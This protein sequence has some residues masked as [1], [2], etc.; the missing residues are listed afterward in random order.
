MNSD[1]TDSLDKKQKFAYQQ[2]GFIK[3][4]VYLHF[5][6]AELNYRILSKQKW[7]APG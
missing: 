5:S 2:S 6:V 7:Q 3:I 1:E 4:R